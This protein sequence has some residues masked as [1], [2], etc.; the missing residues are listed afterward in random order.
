MKLRGFRIEPGEIEAAIAAQDSVKQAVVVVRDGATGK[1]LVA[2]VTPAAGVR[3]DPVAVRNEA[4]KLLPEY[5]I[6]SAVVVL[7]AFPLTPNRKIDRAALATS[8]AWAE[9]EPMPQPVAEPSTETEEELASMTAE[10]LRL[11]RVGVDDDFFRLGGHS[12]LAA[13]LIMR[14]E[15]RL[16]VVLPLPFVFDHPTVRGMA[17]EVDRLVRQAGV[18]GSAGG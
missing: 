1:R 2:Y 10:L 8:Q 18:S 13:Q 11:D 9:P 4:A 7:D 3:A 14:I 15:D 12:M 6:P 5:M 17:G 16:G